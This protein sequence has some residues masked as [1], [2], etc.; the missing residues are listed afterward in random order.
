MGILSC[1]YYSFIDCFD[2]LLFAVDSREGRP[3]MSDV[4][5]LSVISELSFFFLNMKLLIV[6][7]VNS[8]THR[9]N[10]TQSL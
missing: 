3:R 2:L 7:S 10:K 9:T 5:P 1:V 6:I 8:I 4:T